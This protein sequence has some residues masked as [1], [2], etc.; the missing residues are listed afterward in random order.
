MKLYQILLIVGVLLLSSAD[1]S[2]QRRSPRHSPHHR[3]RMERKQLSPVLDRLFMS[4]TFEGVSVTIPYRYTTTATEQQGKKLLVIYLHGRSACGTDNKQPL[5]KPAV[6]ALLDY[7]RTNRLKATL[8]VPQCSDMHRWNEPIYNGTQMTANLKAIIDRFIA[9]G[10]YDTQCI[11]IFGDS[12]GG[13]GVWRLLNDYT[14]LFASAMI[15][16]SRP[17][18][19]DAENV[20]KTPLCVVAGDKDDLAKKGKVKSFIKQL[21]KQ[22]AVTR[23]DIMEKADHRQTC[24]SAFT[25]DRIAWTLSHLRPITD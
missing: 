1:I 7:L 10:E 8:L 14:S 24:D 25:P 12:M 19:V 6:T 2:A 4:D 16:A 17:R 18:D 13:A 22:G 3:P 5:T 9:S 23:F 15:S 11:Y 20:S 21:T